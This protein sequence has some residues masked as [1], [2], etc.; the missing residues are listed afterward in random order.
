ML[1]GHWSRCHFTATKENGWSSQM[2]LHNLIWDL[3]I[4]TSSFQLKTSEFI[5]IVD[6]KPHNCFNGKLQKIIHTTGNGRYKQIL[7]T[8]KF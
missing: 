2:L 7:I 1:I 8:L 6:N 4:H 5:D 3:G